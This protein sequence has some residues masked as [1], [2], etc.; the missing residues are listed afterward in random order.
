MEFLIIFYIIMTILFFGITIFVYVEKVD[1]VKEHEN[2]LYL[3]ML[4]TSIAWP[5]FA[6]R[7]FIN[8]LKGVKK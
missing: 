8:R 6:L 1:R 7:I 4:V 2:L 5:V 3:L